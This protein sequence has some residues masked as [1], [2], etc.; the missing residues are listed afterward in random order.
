MF[1]VDIGISWVRTSPRS[2]L[3]VAR[4]VFL[5]MGSLERGNCARGREDTT[6]FVVEIILRLR[7]SCMVII[8][9]RDRK[10]VGF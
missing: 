7:S 6:I 3:Q 4:N 5:D 8:N 2:P 10:R 9:S 1:V